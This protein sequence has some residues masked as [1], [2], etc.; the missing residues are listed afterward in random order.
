MRFRTIYIALPLLGIVS[1]SSWADYPNPNQVIPEDATTAYPSSNPT[2]TNLNP[3]GVPTGKVNS[4]QTSTDPAS[5][6][7][8]SQ[9]QGQIPGQPT[10]QPQ[11]SPEDRQYKEQMIQI[12]KQIERKTSEVQG[13]ENEINNVIYPTYGPP[14]VA[15]KRELLRELRELEM[16]RDQLQS[17]KTARDYTKQLARPPQ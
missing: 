9:P 11:E 3:V 2:N 1:L 16:R 13:L 17:Q 4:N 8:Q 5:L 7:Q 6:T 14:L 10:K 15:K 12:S